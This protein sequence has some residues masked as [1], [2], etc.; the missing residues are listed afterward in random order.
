MKELKYINIFNYSVDEYPFRKHIQEI[1]EEEEL[2]NIHEKTENF[3]LERKKDQ[4]TK[5]H[6]MF[7]KKY[8]GSSFQECYEKFVTNYCTDLLQVKLI[9]QAK[10][11][12]RIHMPNNVGVGEFHK[13]SDYDHPMEEI[14]FLVPVTEAKETSTIWCETKP[15][16][17]DYAPI[18]LEYGQCL[19]FKG[20]HLKHGNKENKTENTR[21]SF[22]FRVI[23][24]DKYSPS[25][26]GSINTGMKFKIGEYY[27]LLEKK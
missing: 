18:N 14:N 19:I 24:F 17:G 7:Y 11:T 25:E 27:N 23:P 6:K 15:G 26:S 4:S 12:F 8:E 3:F 16:L 1:L 9:N 13:D 5:Q 2:E 10:P 21:V 22:D 20:S